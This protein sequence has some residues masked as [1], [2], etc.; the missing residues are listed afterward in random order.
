VALTAEPQRRTPLLLGLPWTSRQQLRYRLPPGYRV[1][2]LPAAVAAD[3]PFGGFKMD[4]QRAGDEIVVQ[5][6]LVLKTPRVQPAD[7]AS[8]RD[9]VA[10][11]KAA[12]D[13]RLV[14]KKQEA[15]R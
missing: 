5:R 1:D 9:F 7:Y 10:T 6:E 3:T 8:F 12:D 14:A 11:V 13:R 4:W 15:G 2:A